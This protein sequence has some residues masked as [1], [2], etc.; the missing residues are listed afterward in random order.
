MLTGCTYRGYR[1]ERLG[2]EDMWN[3]FLDDELFASGVAWNTALA[4][5]DDV[6]IEPEEPMLTCRKCGHRERLQ[7]MSDVL[8]EMVQHSMCFE[9]NF[10]RDALEDPDIVITQSDKGELE[11]FSVGDEDYGSSFRGYGGRRFT[12]KFF[13]GRVITTTNLWPRGKVPVVWVDEAR[14]HPNQAEITS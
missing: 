5:I 11:A 9:C 12:V 1:L 3:V 8:R 4:R 6:T 7:F 2:K 10:W 14:D 13:D